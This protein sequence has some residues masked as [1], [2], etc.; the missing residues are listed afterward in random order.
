MRPLP[1][2][3]FDGKVYCEILE[4]VPYKKLIYSWKAGPEPGKINMDTIVTWTLVPKAKGTELLLAHTGFTQN[5]NKEIFEAM[6]SGWKKNMGIIE[7]LISKM[8][9][10]VISSQ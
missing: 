1:E 8:Q 3:E 7:E 9:V 10:Q 4:L 6:T 2:M 5:V